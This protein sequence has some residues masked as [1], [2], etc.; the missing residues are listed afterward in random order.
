MSEINRKHE[1]DDLFNS[2][3]NPSGAKKGNQENNQS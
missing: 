3:K 1:T 2:S